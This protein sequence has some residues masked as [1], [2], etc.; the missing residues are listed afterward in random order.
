MDTVVTLQSHYSFQVCVIQEALWYLP[1]DASSNGTARTPDLTISLSFFQ[2]PSST[3]EKEQGSLHFFQRRLHRGLLTSECIF[4]CQV[5][6]SIASINEAKY[7][8]RY[9][10]QAPEPSFCA[11]IDSQQSWT[12]QAHLRIAKCSFNHRTAIV[13]VMAGLSIRKTSKTWRSRYIIE[14]IVDGAESSSTSRHRGSQ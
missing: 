12:P 11:S 14:T 2:F 1:L 8:L 13:I 10:P 7:G 6:T 5:S 9:R 3:L 4:D